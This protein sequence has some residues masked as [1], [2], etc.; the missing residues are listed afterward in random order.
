MWLYWLRAELSIFSHKVCQSDI[1]SH[2]TSYSS[3]LQ[4]CPGKEPWQAEKHLQ[5][6]LKTLL[7]MIF[8]WDRATFT[9]WQTPSGHSFYQSSMLKSS[10]ILPQL[11]LTVPPPWHLFILN[12]VRISWMVLVLRKGSMLGTWKALRYSQEIYKPLLNQSS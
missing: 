5:N 9:M 4:R 2:V 6:A 11:S 8:L 1:P 3:V 12:N 10:N 7:R